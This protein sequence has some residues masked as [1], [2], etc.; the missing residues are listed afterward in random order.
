M[1]LNVIITDDRKIELRFDEWPRQLRADII[2]KI[3]TLTARLHARVLSLEP[4]KTGRLQST[5]VKRIYEDPE[6]IKGAVTVNADFAKAGALEFGAPG[7]RSR[8]DVRGH[9][10]LQTHVFGQEISP[11]RVFVSP[12]HRVARIEARLFMRAGLEGMSGETEGALRGLLDQAT[13]AF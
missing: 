9:Q 2:D 1:D 11:E 10:R 4:K 5:T 12:Y 7:G 13:A 6:K 3:R 8:P